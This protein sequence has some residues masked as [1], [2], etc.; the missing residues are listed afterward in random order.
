MAAAATLNLKIYRAVWTRAHHLALAMLNDS[1]EYR[2]GHGV[3]A[4]STQHRCV[5]VVARLP[6]WEWVA[7]LLTEPKCTV[8]FSSICRRTMVVLK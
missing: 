2:C 5:I 4:A 6:L 3:H 7:G 1:P 8:G